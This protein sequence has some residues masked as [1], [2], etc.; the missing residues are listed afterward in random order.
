MAWLKITQQ[1]LIA[2]PVL[3][4]SLADQIACFVDSDFSILC[5]LSDYSQ[6]SAK[7][8]ALTLN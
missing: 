8:T 2:E 7:F 4:F 5:E 1:P 3:L 6:I